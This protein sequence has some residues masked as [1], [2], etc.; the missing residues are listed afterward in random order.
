M[1]R[2]NESSSVQLVP[3]VTH[4]GRVTAHTAADFADYSQGFDAAG[5]ARGFVAF[6]VLRFD[7]VLVHV[8]D[9]EP[10]RVVAWPATAR[11]EL[12]DGAARFWKLPLGGRQRMWFIYD[13]GVVNS[14]QFA[15]ARLRSLYAF[16]YGASLG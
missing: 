6:D 7:C 12:C 1:M 8:I 14:P 5:Y 13:N 15:L 9:D 4:D 16:V 10:V 11:K 3:F 2:N